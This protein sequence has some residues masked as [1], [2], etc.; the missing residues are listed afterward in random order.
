MFATVNPVTYGVDAARALM[1]DR[2]V[3]TVVEVSSFGGPLD[4]V[5]P[6][7]AVLLA[8]AGS[9]G[10]VAVTLLSRATSSDVR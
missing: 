7:V 3:M 2:D 6:A 4:S 1:L 8:L 9:F 5:I 10:A